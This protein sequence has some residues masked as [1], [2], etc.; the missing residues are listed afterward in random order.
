MSDGAPANDAVISGLPDVRL[1]FVGATLIAD[2]LAIGAYLS[3]SD[4]S[5]ILLFLLSALATSQLGLLGVW[6]G[7]ARP[8]FLPTRLLVSAVAVGGW[9]TAISG[10]RWNRL[11]FSPLLFYYLL[12]PTLVA[13]G[14]WI[15]RLAGLRL[16]RVSDKTEP[17]PA[18]YQ[19]SLRQLFIWT[20]IV[21]VVATA[22]SLLIPFSGLIVVVLAV[23]IM[24]ALTW[25]CV[26][27]VLGQRVGR[28]PLA[29][30]VF[31]ILLAFTFS[32]LFGVPVIHWPLGIMLLHCLLTVLS[33]AV[34]RACGYRVGWQA[35]TV[36]Q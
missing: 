4:Q 5:G 33:L 21:A 1:L 17:S 18:R 13:G 29:L 22:A 11:E 2:A 35:M 14:L 8:L 34:F 7:V 36:E 16:Y 9:M 3:W 25:A 26:W 20:T 31:A 12:L 27:V 10:F 32:L 19:F 24:A 15:G 28:R 6:I 23:F 30:A